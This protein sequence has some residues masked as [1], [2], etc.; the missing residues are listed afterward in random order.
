MGEPKEIQET[1]KIRGGNPV[2]ANVDQ[3]N[4]SRFGGTLHEIGID[5]SRMLLE[6]RGD[7]PETSHETPSPIVAG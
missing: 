4:Q 6:N 3:I 7:F 1:Q 2:L 5:L